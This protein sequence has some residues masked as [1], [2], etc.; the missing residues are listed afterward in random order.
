MKI[1]LYCICSVMKIAVTGQI[2]YF[3]E[4]DSWAVNEVY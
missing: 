4:E 3:C 1:M 2:Q